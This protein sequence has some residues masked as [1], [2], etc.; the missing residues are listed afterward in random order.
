[1]PLLVRKILM[2]FQGVMAA[3]AGSKF[4]IMIRAFQDFTRGFDFAGVH[5]QMIQ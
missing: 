5:D 4:E 1:M 2:D 3:G